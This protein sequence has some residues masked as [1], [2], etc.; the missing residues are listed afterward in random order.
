MLFAGS[1]GRPFRGYGLYASLS[2]D[3]GASWPVRRL[4]TP[5]SGEYDTQ[6]HT[7]Q[8]RADATHAEPRGYLAAAQ[9][10]DGIIHLISSGLH[11][12]FN[13]KWLTEE[14]KQ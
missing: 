9:T 14:E 5:G 10:P 13:L 1:G 8:F 3:E 4:L 11:Y 2:F 12:R 6:G 7:R